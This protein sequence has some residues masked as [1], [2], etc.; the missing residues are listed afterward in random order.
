MWKTWPFSCSIIYWPDFERVLNWAEETSYQSGLMNM[1]LLCTRSPSHPKWRH[2]GEQWWQLRN[3]LYVNII[4]YNVV[5]SLGK[6]WC[7]LSLS[8]SFCFLKP[9]QHFQEKLCDT[10]ICWSF[11]TIISCAQGHYK[12]EVNQIQCEENMFTMWKRWSPSRPADR[13]TQDWK[14]CPRYHK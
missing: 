1:Y 10:K 3:S 7:I 11:S 6:A 2:I 4:R 12:S 5:I 9:H 13:P 14:I 8:P